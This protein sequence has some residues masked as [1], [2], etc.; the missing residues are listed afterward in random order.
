MENTNK[1]EP[2]TIICNHC[3]NEFT[4]SPA[5]QKYYKSHEYQLP[6][7]CHEC[8]KLRKEKKTLTCLDCNAAF[9]I[10]AIQEAYY[11]ENGYELPKRCP[12]CRKFK[13]ARNEKGDE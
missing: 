10:N 7:K 4:M 1:I 9:E 12:E 13:R 5:E 2:K 11:K 8:R 6:K 3:G